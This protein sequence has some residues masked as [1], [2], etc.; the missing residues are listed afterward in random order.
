MQCKVLRCSV[1]AVAH[2]D[3][4]Q[5]LF[6]HTRAPN[7]VPNAH[8]L[9]LQLWREGVDGRP[10]APADALAAHQPGI[11]ILRAQRVAGV[12]LCWHLRLLGACCCLRDN[13]A[14]ASAF[15]A[16]TS[17]VVP[18]QYAPVAEPLHGANSFSRATRC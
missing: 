1:E 3:I 18:R 13:V 8:L 4:K 9:I 16:A 11:A 2:L 12:R 10:D 5:I 15:Q 17:C 6:V 14:D 7:A